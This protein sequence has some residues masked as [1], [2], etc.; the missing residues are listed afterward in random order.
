MNALAYAL[1]RHVATKADR[2]NIRTE[3]KQFFQNL[4]KGISNIPENEVGQIKT[5]L[6]NT[7]E[8]HCNV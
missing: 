4:L 1:D 2:N 3:F 5:K 8:K 6:C 7:C